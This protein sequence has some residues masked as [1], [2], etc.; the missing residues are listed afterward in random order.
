M[1]TP[2]SRFMKTSLRLVIYPL[3]VKIAMPPRATIE[4]I[5][6]QSHLHTYTT[7]K[8]RRVNQVPDSLKLSAWRA[9]TRS[10]HDNREKNILAACGTSPVKLVHAVSTLSEPAGD[11]RC[12]QLSVYRPHFSGIDVDHGSRKPVRRDAIG[13]F[14]DQ[15]HAYRC[16][17]P[18]RNPGGGFEQ[19]SDRR[20]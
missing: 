1:K 3:A 17:P 16:R 18:G 2:Y 9:E 15:T 5:N 6:L 20:I 11:M 4:T 7:P 10:A 19:Q 8:A 14:Y 12:G 13:D